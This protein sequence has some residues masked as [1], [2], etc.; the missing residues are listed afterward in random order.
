MKIATFLITVLV[1][2]GI[3]FVMFFMLILG[4][5]GFHEDEATP[6]LLLYIIW[7]L[8]SAIITGVLGILPA[9][10]L[11][12]KKSVNKI[13]ATAISTVIFIIVGGVS[14][15]VGFFAALMAA[16]AMR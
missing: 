13:A 4:M 6:G 9:N 3:A 2:G 16:S 1:N 8:L 15:M 14:V 10:Y 11:A 7:G 5:N 12:T